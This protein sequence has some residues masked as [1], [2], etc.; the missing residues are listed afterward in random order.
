[1]KPGQFCLAL[2]DEAALLR[3]PLFPASPT[4]FVIEAAHPVAALEPGATLDLIGPL[5]AGFS[6]PAGASRLLIIAEQPAR[7]LAL[8]RTALAQHWSVA[9]HWREAVPA[10]A[11]AL[12]PPD[13]EFHSGAL[14]AETIEWAE[15]VILDVPDPAEVAER[16]RALRPLRP[17]GFIQTLRVPL[18]PCGVGACQ[19]CW[20]ETAR[21]RKLACVEGPIFSI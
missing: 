5:G 14:I 16:V 21:G 19:A 15:V 7:I 2:L 9:W 1:M 18:M 13:V 3:E 11:A 8:M 6:L 20:V 17:A 4:D 12:L 10:W